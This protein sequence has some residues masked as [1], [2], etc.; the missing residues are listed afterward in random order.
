MSRNFIL[1]WLE[2]LLAWM[3]SNAQTDTC[4]HTETFN[5]RSK[6]YRHNHIHSS[7]MGN[8]LK[9][10]DIFNQ[11]FFGCPFSFLT[12]PMMHAFGQAI[13]NVSTAPYISV[14]QNCHIFASLIFHRITKYLLCHFVIY[15]FILIIWSSLCHYMQSNLSM[16]P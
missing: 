5:H 8:A 10:L 9:S 14:L 11:F 16:K 1:N 7:E 12:T 13:S 2:L 6:H 15:S 4:K 3:L